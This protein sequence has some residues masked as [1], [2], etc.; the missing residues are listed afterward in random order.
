MILPWEYVKSLKS[1]E[2]YRE[3]PNVI[4]IN[5]DERDLVLTNSLEIHFLNMVQ[6]RK[7]T[8]GFNDSLGNDPLIRW[9]AW[10]NEHSPPELVA[11]VKRMDSAINL[12]DERLVY[13]SGDEDAIRAY[14]IRFKAMCDWTSMRDYATETGHAAGFEK[15]MAE[16]R[17]EGMVEGREE[18]R[19]EGRAEGK[20]EVTRIMKEMGDSIERIQ[21]ITGLA[22][23]TVV[24][25]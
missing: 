13:L 21:I 12:A 6:Y 11:E 9:L 2:N 3:L 20:L 15:G 5:I 7:L 19:A 25:L 18:G 23:E 14:E 16:G 24:Q 22:G 4:A 1:G 8:K 10:F 17:A